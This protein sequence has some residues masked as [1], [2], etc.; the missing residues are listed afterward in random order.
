[1]YICHNASCRASEGGNLV[2]LVLLLS[3]RNDSEALRLIAK[4]GSETAVPLAEKL[5][6]MQA[7]ERWPML[8][9]LKIDELVENLWAD[10]RALQYLADY[11]GFDELT[12]K[13]F[14]VGYDPDK[15][16]VVV[17][18]HD[19]DG[20]PIGVNGRSIEGKR[21]KLTKRLP[22][23]KVLFNMH[24]AKQSGGTVIMCESQF[25]VMRIDQAGFPN[26][27]CAMGSHISKEQAH[28]LQRYFDRIIIATDADAAG[29]KMGH[30]LSAMVP[31]MRVEWAI[32]DWGVIYPHDAKDAGDMTLEEIRYVINN[33][34]GDLAYKSFKSLA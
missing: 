6:A 7:E 24:R 30:T 26:A 19:K 32:H 15:D 23:N 25:D 8:P 2:K 33:S 27:V 12:I 11:R 3:N 21:F 31:G 5:S 9:Q 16:M 34:V 28:L 20:N 29:R 22:R 13:K 10:E 17:P 1:M 14:E 18:I 4:K